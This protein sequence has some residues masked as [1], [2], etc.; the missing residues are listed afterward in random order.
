MRVCEEFLCRVLVVKYSS[1]LQWS[2]T[3]RLCRVRTQVVGLQ[4]YNKLAGRQHYHTIDANSTWKVHIYTLLS[5]WTPKTWLCYNSTRYTENANRTLDYSTVYTGRP[6]FIHIHSRDRTANAH[7]ICIST[8]NWFPVTCSH[9]KPNHTDT[10]RR[11]KLTK[12]SIVAYFSI[13][14]FGPEQALS[15]C[16]LCWACPQCY[17]CSY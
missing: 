5:W 13:V 3:R 4:L 16:Q 7:R 14:G 15:T 10:N 1:E 6:L 11:R 2:S 12:Y 8:S 17:V 9:C